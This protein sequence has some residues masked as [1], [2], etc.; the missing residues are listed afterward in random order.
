MKNVYFRINYNN[1]GIYEA[2]KSELWRISDD[3]KEEWIKLKDSNVFNWLKVP[4]ISYD[5]CY[6]Y[7][8]KDGFDL[9]MKNTYPIFVKYLDADKINIDSFEFD[10]NELNI[11]YED[12][13]QIVVKN[14]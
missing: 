5:D 2:F 13:Y 10:L 8:N 3:P 6:S 11:I 1:V 4:N 9:F 7:F 12:E 14:I